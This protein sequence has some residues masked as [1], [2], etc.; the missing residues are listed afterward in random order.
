MQ[1]DDLTR[2][3]HC[4]SLI[5]GI[6]LIVAALGFAFFPRT[7]EAVPNMYVANYNG[8]SIT[9]A[10]LDG[11]N[12]VNLG[13]PG[14]FLNGPQGIALSSGYMYVANGS[15]NTITRADLPN[16][17]NPMDLGNPGGFLN[18]PYGIALDLRVPPPPHRLLQF[19]LSRNGV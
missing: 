3:P 2:S 15:G 19:Q 16:G 12:S 14:G 17:S 13:N 5:A 6:A 10:D 11:L 7:A 9:C 18:N 4:L 1:N 8:N